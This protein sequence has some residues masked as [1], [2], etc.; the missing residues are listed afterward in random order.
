M[1]PALRTV[2]GK[3]SKWRAGPPGSDSYSGVDCA[4]AA[5]EPESEDQALGSIGS[6]D[7]PALIVSTF[8][9]SSLSW[10]HRASLPIPLS[11][12]SPFSSHLHLYC[13]VCSEELSILSL[14]YLLFL[15]IVLILLLWHTFRRTLFLLFVFFFPS[16]LSPVETD[17]IGRVWDAE[18]EESLLLYHFTN[19]RGICEMKLAGNK[20]ETEVLSTIAFYVLVINHENRVD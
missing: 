7:S 20:D 19:V 13:S 15:S 8:L 18:I 1:A 5:G 2:H 11:I 4:R 16:L 14:P 3:Q 12:F 6:F 9:Y 17:L 10:Y